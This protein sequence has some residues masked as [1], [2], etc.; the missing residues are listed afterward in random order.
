MNLAAIGR[1]FG[2]STVPSAAADGAARAEPSPKTA[3]RDIRLSSGLLPGE[4]RDLT[5]YAAVTAY[6]E[7]PVQ[8]TVSQGSKSTHTFEIR[9]VADFKLLLAELAT[10][11]AP[12]SVPEIP[13]GVRY[14]LFDRDKLLQYYGDLTANPDPPGIIGVNDRRNQMLL[15]SASHNAAENRLGYPQGLPLHITY[16]PEAGAFKI[17]PLDAA[18][19]YRVECLRSSTRGAKRSDDV[20]TTFS[21]A[22]GPSD[23]STS[24]LHGEIAPLTPTRATLAEMRQLNVL[25]RSGGAL[26]TLHVIAREKLQ[27][28]GYSSMCDSLPDGSHFLCAMMGT[29]VMFGALPVAQPVLIG[30]D[31]AFMGEKRLQL[32]ESVSRAHM[33]ITLR[34]DHL[35]VLRLPNTSPVIVA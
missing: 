2:I 4:L 5:P 1:L 9:S 34:P 13:D 28:I 16:L 31:S 12:R 29:P 3:T 30:R 17:T 14:L 33:L 8:C 21:H 25:S 18:Y 11:Q 23:N 20:P 15:G 10:G 7:G 22:D 26:Y 32:P 6:Y 24:G 27:Q 19:T 35:E